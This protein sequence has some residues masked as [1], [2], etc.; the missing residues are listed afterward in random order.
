MPSSSAVPS[1]CLR[2]YCALTLACLAPAALATLRPSASVPEWLEPEV[3]AI[4]TGIILPVNSASDLV[5]ALNTVA[6]NPD[7]DYTINFTASI[8]LGAPTQLPAITTRSSVTIDGHGRALDGGGVQR[9]FFVYSGNVTIQ[10]LTI[11]NTLAQGG[12]GGDGGGGGGMGA[13]GALFIHDGN[14]TVSNLALLNNQAVGGSGGF[15]N[16]LT[17]LGGGGGGMGGDG[18]DGGDFNLAPPFQGGGGGGGLGLSATGGTAGGNG[19]PGMLPGGAA[20]GAGS[21]GGTGGNNGGGGGSGPQGGGGGGGLGGTSGSLSG[22]F[23]GFGGG[24]GGVGSFSGVTAG[25]GGFGGGGGGGG[26]NRP[27]GFGGFGGGG[28]GG[29][30]LNSGGGFGGGGGGGLT[31]GISRRGGGGLGAGGAIF[32]HGGSLTVKGS[33]TINGNTVAGGAGANNGSAFGSG[34]FLVNPSGHTLSPP[35]RLIF[36]PAAGETQTISDVIADQL[37]NGA[38]NPSLTLVRW[39][40]NLDG[41]GTLIL[42]APNTF[43][44]G[45]TVSQGMLIV[46][47][48]TDSATGRIGPVAVLNGAAL[49][50]TGSIMADLVLQA[51]AFLAPGAGLGTLTVNSGSGV[52]WNAGAEVL[53]TLGTDGTSSFLH[54]PGGPLTKLGSG[55]YVFN[56]HGTGTR[57]KI[58]VLA[59]YTGTNFIAADFSYIGLPPGMNGSFQ[60]LPTQLQ[61][62]IA[63]LAPVISSPPTAAGTT[64]TSF[65]YSITASNSPTTFGVTGALPA[66]LALD[67][68]TGII[69]GTPSQAGTFLVTLRASNATGTGTQALTIT[70]TPPPPVPPSVPA[71]KL[72]SK[73]GGATS[74]WFLAA[75]ALASA[76]RWRRHRR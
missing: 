24:G 20:G 60:V 56:F 34:I 63:P 10:N 40:L 58:Y 7:Q 53:C 71:P 32:F 4:T 9:G 75:L 66:G 70:I 16:S 6:S 76:A 25:Y 39:G 42:S 59:Q 50:G 13:G 68:V 72:G 11:Q 19:A 62:T 12:N 1:F 30:L 29:S 36:A 45:V 48:L 61:F 18:G 21:N 57:G 5:A 3:H 64:G 54:I 46:N 47:N 17:L 37:G 43:S 22:G 73:G 38:E 33:L 8:T 65:S 55:S 23:G 67:N 31:G 27:G 15:N 69:A 2:G 28:G 52:S 44:G 41:P 49:A 51:G 14:V 26:R 35:Q 74:H